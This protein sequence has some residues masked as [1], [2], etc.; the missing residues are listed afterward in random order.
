MST[1]PFHYE[2]RIFQNFIERQYLPKD[3]AVG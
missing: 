3:R 2:D 1:F